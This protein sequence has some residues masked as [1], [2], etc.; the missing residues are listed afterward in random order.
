MLIYRA[1]MLRSGSWTMEGKLA[2]PALP[3]RAGPR[4]HGPKSKASNDALRP[5]LGAFPSDAHA[6]TARARSSSRAASCRPAKPS[7]ANRLLQTLPVTLSALLSLFFYVFPASASR[8]PRSALGPFLQIRGNAS[9]NN[10]TYRY[11][12]TPRPTTGRRQAIAQGRNTACRLLLLLLYHCGKAR[13]GCRSTK[14][15]YQ[16][17]PCSVPKTF[18][19]YF[20]QAAIHTCDVLSA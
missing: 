16:R 17:Y 5:H 6:G 4:H 15:A 3:P 8:A 10:Q 12:E 18:V 13:L 11:G 9:S 14:A 2:R 20:C 19:A 1:Q 7:D